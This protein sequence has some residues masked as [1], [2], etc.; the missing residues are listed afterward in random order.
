LWK[1]CTTNVFLNEVQATIV[2]NE[3]SDLLSVL[4][5]LDSDALTNGR[6]RLLSF[7]TA[8]KM[9]KFV[10][11]PDIEESELESIGRYLHFFEYDAL[12]M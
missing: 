9:K 12:S 8:G 3:S 6:V 2:G 7:N 5:Q 11:L 10:S 4:D 1:K